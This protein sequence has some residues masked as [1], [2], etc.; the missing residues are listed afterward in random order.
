MGGGWTLGTMVVGK[1]IQVIK[2]HGI[3]Q[4]GWGEQ[5]SC[6][7]ALCVCR[8]VAGWCGVAAHP[9]CVRMFLMSST[10]STKLYTFISS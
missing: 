3:R 1:V 9:T 7:C 4:C 10:N 5:A 2:T 8:R 6:V